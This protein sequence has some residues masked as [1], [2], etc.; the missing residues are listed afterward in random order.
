MAISRLNVLHWHMMDDESFSVQLAT[1]PELAEAAAYS[2]QQTYH[3]NDLNTLIALAN[4]NAVQIVPEVSSPTRMRSW[5]QS[6]PWN[7]KNLTINC[8]PTGDEPKYCHQLDPSKPEGVQ[9]LQEV[10]AE[11]DQ[12]FSKS[13]YLHL[14]GEGVSEECWD[15]RPSI[16]SSFM[17][18]HNIKDYSGLV[19]YLR[20]KVKQALPSSR[21]VIYWIDGARDYSAAEGD[22]L[23]F[24]GHS[25]DLPEGNS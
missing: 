3:L 19:E 11:V 18:L 15:S 14:G 10:V 17:K 2:P 24:K 16:K 4:K 13:P 23:Q 1:H 21:K 7:T 6:S 20:F 12:I 25:A 8:K 22:I 9:L 5:V